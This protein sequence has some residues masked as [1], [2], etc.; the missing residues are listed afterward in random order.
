MTEIDFILKSI[1]PPLLLVFFFNV[2]ILC[3]VPLCFA[4]DARADTNAALQFVEFVCF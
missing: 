2:L 1:V 4:V 3:I